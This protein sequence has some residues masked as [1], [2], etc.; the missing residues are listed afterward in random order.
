MFTHSV[1]NGLQRV[2]KYDH[3][4]FDKKIIAMCRLILVIVILPFTL[5]A[6]LTRSG[7]EGVIVDGKGQPLVNVKLIAKAVEGTKEVEQLETITGSDGTFRFEHLSL[8]TAYL[9]IPRAEQWQTDSQFLAN[10]GS[11]WRNTR[12]EYPLV[13]RFTTKNGVIT[14]TRTGLE[15]LPDSGNGFT[16]IG[17]G[18]SAKLFSSARGQCGWRLPTD[19][20]L[21]EIYS[22]R[23]LGKQIRIDSLFRLRSP[24]VWT[25]SM[26]DYENS[27]DEYYKTMSAISL[28]STALGGLFEVTT[29]RP[30]EYL[31]QVKAMTGKLAPLA[32]Y[33]DFSNGSDRWQREDE[34]GED[35]RTLMVRIPCQAN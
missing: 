31:D 33:F 29:D 23:A 4:G 17:A 8:S 32:K 21:T 34:G 1:I 35:I 2:L 18:N 30:N 24:F 12:L 27:P 11:I 20:E 5:S 13:I 9:L 25:S 3:R 14:D 7:I 16:W 15:W 6:C 10:S 26:I 28:E 22:F 19:N